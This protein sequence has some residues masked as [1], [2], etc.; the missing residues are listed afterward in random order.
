[1]DTLIIL[2]L[3]GDPTLPAVSVKNTG[4]FQVDIQELLGKINNPIANKAKEITNNSAL[5]CPWVE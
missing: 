3:L 2:C 1:M 5:K 4:G